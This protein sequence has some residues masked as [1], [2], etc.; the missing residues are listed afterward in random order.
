VSI[1]T[2]SF[3]IDCVL[4][5]LMTLFICGHRV[6][7]GANNVIIVTTKLLSVNPRVIFPVEFIS[8]VKNMVLISQKL[9]T[10]RIQ[11]IISVTVKI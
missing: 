1:V 3:R 6:R 2:N 8:A 11:Y 10:N 5:P 7:R 4:Q 9:Q